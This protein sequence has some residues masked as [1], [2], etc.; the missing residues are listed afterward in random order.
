MR[1]SNRRGLLAMAKARQFATVLVASASIPTVAI[2][3]VVRRQAPAIDGLAC[4]GD[5]FVIR[6]SQP[7]PGT[8]FVVFGNRT[9]D[10]TVIA[11]DQ[12]PADKA[13]QLI[14][15]FRP[16]HRPE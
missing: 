3:D 4:T 5:D 11:V 15:R 12:L 9:W 1:L 6:G 7:A 8:I 16:G 14:E 2:A 10:Q 13:L